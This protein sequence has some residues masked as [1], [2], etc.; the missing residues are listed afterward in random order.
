VLA[1]LLTGRP[2]L[3][4]FLVRSLLLALQTINTVPH[5][6]V[7]SGHPAIQFPICCASLHVPGM[8]GNLSPFTASIPAQPSEQQKQTAA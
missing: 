8:L 3:P 7:N 5:V 6:I 4:P 1:Y 2:D